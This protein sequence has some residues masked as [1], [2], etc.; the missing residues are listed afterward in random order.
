VTRAGLI[1]AT[2][3][4]A[5]A[6]VAHAQKLQWADVVY[7]PGAWQ[8]GRLVPRATTNTATDTLALV[9]RVDY[10]ANAPRWRAEI[11]RS[12]DGVNFGD[13]TVLLG[14]RTSASVVTQLGA[15]PLDQHALGRDSLVRAAIVFGADGRRTGAPSGRM[16]DRAASGVVLRVAF[17]RSQRTATFSDDILDPRG[18]SAGRQ[19]IASRLTSVGDQRSASVVATAG[20]RGVDR[21]RT[22]RGEVPVRPDSMAIVRMEHFSVGAL[23][24]EDFLRQGGLGPYKAAEG[25]RP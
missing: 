14:E 3:L 9:M 22:P 16:V 13:P 18:Q 21:V 15:T 6:G 8:A 12:S 10:F 4:A 11:R 2:L 24:L 20:A 19:L 25:Q 23:R 1:A 5:A 17:R 7:V